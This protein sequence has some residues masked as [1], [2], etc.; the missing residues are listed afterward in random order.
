MDHDEDLEWRPEDEEHHDVEDPVNEEEADEEIPSDS[1]DEDPAILV[2]NL[3]IQAPPLP[4]PQKREDDVFRIT[5]VHRML[6]TKRE[7]NGPVQKMA[8]V[9]MAG[10]LQSLITQ[11]T[12][13]AG[14]ITQEARRKI[15]TPHDI[16]R[17]CENHDALRQ[18]T[19]HHPTQPIT[20]S[21]QPV[22]RTTR[23]AT[24]NVD[25]E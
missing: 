18:L 16:Q 14:A 19:L 2:Q 20:L 5:T 23:K 1:D 9:Y 13:R 21:R 4:A 10:V 11:V 8:A 25:D 17:A 22:P 12:E 3:R 6:K 15:I 24:A 7:G